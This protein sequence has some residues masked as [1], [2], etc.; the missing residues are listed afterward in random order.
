MG[1][2]CCVANVEQLRNP[3]EKAYKELNGDQRTEGPVEER[4]GS[5]ARKVKQEDA[6]IIGMGFRSRER[7]AG[8]ECGQI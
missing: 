1:D 3:K 2:R 6:S 7:G 5:G 4:N 8:G